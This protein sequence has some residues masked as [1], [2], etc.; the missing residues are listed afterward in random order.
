MQ[1]VYNDYHKG[2]MQSHAHTP[3]VLGDKRELGIMLPPELRKVLRKK[4]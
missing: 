2:I 4:S 3:S 1:V